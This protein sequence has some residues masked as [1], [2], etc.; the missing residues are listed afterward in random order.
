[1]LRNLPANFSRGQLED[2][3]ADAQTRHASLA[4]APATTAQRLRPHVGPV[5]TA[6]DKSMSAPRSSTFPPGCTSCVVH[7]G[8][9]PFAAD[10]SE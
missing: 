1:M 2:N 10:F 3:A 6:V 8:V 5:G 4:Q 9:S 7:F